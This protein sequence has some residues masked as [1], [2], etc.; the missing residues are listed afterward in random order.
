MKVHGNKK[1]SAKTEKVVLLLDEIFLNVIDEYAKLKNMSRNG[2]I[3]A[4]VSEGISRIM[5][6]EVYSSRKKNENE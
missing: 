3:R 6:G 1:D 4:M 2:F 5:V